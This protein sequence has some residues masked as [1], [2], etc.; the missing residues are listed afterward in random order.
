MGALISPSDIVRDPC[1]FC[2]TLFSV[3]GVVHMVQEYTKASERGGLYRAQL[4]GSTDII[5]WPSLLSWDLSI[6]RWCILN[7][8]ACDFEVVYMYPPQ[9]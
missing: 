2:F 9:K 5:S 1:T 3:C 7:R 8:V 4:E 6:L